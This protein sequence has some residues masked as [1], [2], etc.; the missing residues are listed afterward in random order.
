MAYTYLAIAIIVEVAGTIA[1]KA[2]ESFT[3]LVPSVVVIVG[4]G[5]SAY[6]F[7]LVL[8]TLP[9]GITYAIW[10]GSGIALVAGVSAIIYKQIPD[11]A[12][13]LGITLIILGIAVITL[14]SK[15]ANL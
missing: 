3:N 13:M 10:A 2:S 11:L 5:L 1:L 12:A 14:F 7:S 9:V 8:R 4:Y 15:T 6:L